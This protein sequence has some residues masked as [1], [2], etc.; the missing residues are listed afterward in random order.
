MKILDAPRLRGCEVLVV[1]LCLA[2]SAAADAQTVAARGFVDIGATALSASDSFEATTGS[3]TAMAIGGGAQALFRRNIG[4]LF[5]VSRL[6]KEGER[7]FV[8]DGETFPLGIAS[9]ITVTPIE[10]GG[11]YRFINRDPRARLTPVVGGGVGWHRYSETS[12][13]AEPGE[14][15]SETFAGYHVLGGAEFRLTRWVHVGGE[16][17]WTTVPDALGQD[18]NSVSAAFGETNLGGTSF[19]VTL[20]IGR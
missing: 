12:E 17:Q 19:R 13:F 4:I 9:T 3:R 18:P 7:V 8:L 10:V 20:V 5:R 11:T 2:W 15:V 1:C 16:A 6:R 14:D